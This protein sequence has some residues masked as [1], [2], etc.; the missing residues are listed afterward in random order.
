MPDKIANAPELPFGTE[1]Y[2]GAFNDLSSCRPGG[3][4]LS[5]IPWSAIN[6]YAD[7]MNYDEDQKDDLFLFVRLMDKAYMNYHREKAEQER[8]K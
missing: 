7:V 1:L 2:Y 5:P 3:F 8:Q 6:D 4:G